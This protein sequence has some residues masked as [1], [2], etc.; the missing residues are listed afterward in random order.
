MKDVAEAVVSV[1]HLHLVYRDDEYRVPN[2]GF[3]AGGGFP[4]EVQQVT[5]AL[6]RPGWCG[7]G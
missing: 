1:C 2:A 7:A 3:G 4:D 6:D 5:G